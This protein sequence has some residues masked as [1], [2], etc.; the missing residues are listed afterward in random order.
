MWGSRYF[1]EYIPATLSAPVFWNVNGHPEWVSNMLR[2]CNSLPVPRPL[3]LLVRFEGALGGRIWAPTTTKV[4]AGSK[5]DGP[6]LSVAYPSSMARAKPFKATDS[7]RWRGADEGPRS[8]SVGL[9]RSA[10][11][12]ESPV[13]PHILIKSWAGSAS[14][15]LVIPLQYYIADSYPK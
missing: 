1:A 14:S 4:A 13:Q 6:R 3:R 10:Y 9:L 11:L 15:E 8:V 7:L 2:L 5:G 12:R